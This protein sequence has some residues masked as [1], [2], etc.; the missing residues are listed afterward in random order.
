MIIYILLTIQT[1]LL[2]DFTVLL[3]LTYALCVCK[4]SLHNVY[5]VSTECNLLS[6]C[7]A[8]VITTVFYI[9]LMQSMTLAKQSRYIMLIMWIVICVHLVACTL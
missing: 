5:H 7:N 4:N 2:D 9:V 3:I 1:P 8:V 6:K